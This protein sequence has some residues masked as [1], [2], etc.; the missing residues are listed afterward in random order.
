MQVYITDM[1]SG[2]YFNQSMERPIDPIL[3][4]EYIKLLGGLGLYDARLDMSDSVTTEHPED[5]R[6]PELDYNP[7]IIL[8]TD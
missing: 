6:W 3:D 8:G 2:E 5:S 4:A 7:D 1:N